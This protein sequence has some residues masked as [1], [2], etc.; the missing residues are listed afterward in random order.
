L[1]QVTVRLEH[2]RVHAA[3]CRDAETRPCVVDH[4][5]RTIRLDGPLTGEQRARLLALAERCPVHRTL[6]GEVRVATRLA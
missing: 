4:I 3:D 1:E 2:D 5:D 6:T